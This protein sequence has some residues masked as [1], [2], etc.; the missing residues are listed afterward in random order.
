MDIFM[1]ILN[2]NNIVRNAFCFTNLSLAEGQFRTLAKELCTEASKEAI[3]VA[4]EDG[5]IEH[6]IENLALCLYQGWTRVQE[7]KE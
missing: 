3:E 2:E 7:E 6:P 1:V 5:Y 4:L